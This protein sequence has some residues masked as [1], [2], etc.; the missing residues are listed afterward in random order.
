MG[1]REKDTNKGKLTKR[2]REKEKI[3]IGLGVETERETKID[4]VT[5]IRTNGGREKKEKN[6]VPDA[7]DEFSIK[8]LVVDTP[9]TPPLPP[10]RR[11]VA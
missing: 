2:K 9:P 8:V 3:F 4:K 1:Q 6:F 7:D 11:C 10:I 5:K